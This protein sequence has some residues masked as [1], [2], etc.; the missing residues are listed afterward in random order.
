MKNKKA[1]CLV[2]GGL[3]SA[4]AAAIAIDKGYEPIFLFLR[5]GQKTQKK[6]EWCFDELVKFWMIKQA[7]KVDLPWIKEF[8]G[9]ALFEKDI[10]LDE[11]NFWLEYVPFRNSIFLSIATALAEV[12][13]ADI[14]VIGSTG[15]DHVCPDNSQ[16]FHDSFQKVVEIG[17][18]LKKDIKIFHPLTETNKTGVVSI[19]NKLKVPFKYTW[20][21]HNKTD[22]ACGHCSNCLARIEAYKLNVSTDPIEYEKQ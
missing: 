11:M 5:Y 19:G 21:C 2:S 12:K 10:S 16:E 4:V 22:F 6:E 17:T 20:S 7:Y 18:M 8:G 3:D 1:V 13:G 15:G 14:V 9:S